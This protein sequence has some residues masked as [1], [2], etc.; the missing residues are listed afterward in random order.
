MVS[1]LETSKP[2]DPS[3]DLV[4]KTAISW[5]RPG[6][7]AGRGGKAGGGL[8]LDCCSD[9]PVS[10][11]LSSRDVLF[12]GCLQQ[13]QFIPSKHSLPSLWALLGLPGGSHLHALRG[14]ILIHKLFS[15]VSFHSKFSLPSQWAPL[16]LPGGAHLQAPRGLFLSH[17]LFSFLF[18]S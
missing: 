11:P 10:F 6:G 12:R 14:V 9:A 1:D 17:E 7:E 18:V 15:I 16:G 5:A 13:V 8:H 4:S 2:A 3:G